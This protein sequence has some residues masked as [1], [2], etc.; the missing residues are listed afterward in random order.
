MQTR[1]GG[2]MLSVAGRIWACEGP[3][4]FYKVRPVISANVCFITLHNKLIN[5]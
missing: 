5:E 3:L 4:A 2:N 1:G